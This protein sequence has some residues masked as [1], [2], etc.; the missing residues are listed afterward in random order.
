MLIVRI[1]SYHVQAFLFLPGLFSFSFLVFARGIQILDLAVF[2]DD[3][4]GG[5]GGAM[6]C[7]LGLNLRNQGRARCWLQILDIRCEVVHDLGVLRPHNLYQARMLARRAN[8]AGLEGIA[9]GPLDIS[10]ARGSLEE[11]ALVPDLR[12]RLPLRTNLQLLAFKSGSD[13]RDTLLDFLAQLFDFDL[14][15]AT[16]NW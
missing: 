11:S 2:F 6:W 1:L 3:L 16:R 13:L 5:T 15:I 8:E 7:E 9:V 4:F 12:A 14:E 10:L